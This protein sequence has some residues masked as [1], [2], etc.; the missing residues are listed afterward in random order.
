MTS[1]NGIY[2][3]KKVNTKLMNDS[4]QKKKEHNLDWVIQPKDDFT[5]L[6]VWY[7]ESFTLSGI[8]NKIATR[9]N[10]WFSYFEVDDKFSSDESKK[11]YQFLTSIDLEAIFTDMVVTGNHFLEVIKS[12]DNTDARTDRVLVETIRI[13]EQNK[14]D[15]NGITSKVRSYVQ[16]INSV[17]EVEFNEWEIIHFKT[18]NI[19]DK[20]YGKSRLYSVIDQ[21]ILLTNIDKFY[22][23][24]M[25]RGNM[26]INLLTD[27]DNKLTKAQK[28]AIASLITDAGSGLDNAFSTLIIPSWVEKI[29]LEDV[30]DT[31]AFLEYR[32]ELI[33]SVCIW[34]NF[35]YE[36]L[37]ADQ[38]NKSTS[39]VALKTL[40]EDVI[41]PLQD[42]VLKTIKDFLKQYKPLWEIS[43]DLIELI[44]FKMV[45]IENEKEKAEVLTTYVKN[46]VMT[47]NEARDLSPYNLIDR[48]DGDDFVNVS[49]K[50]DVTANPWASDYTIEKISKTISSR[51]TPSLLQKMQNKWLVKNANN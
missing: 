51:Y 16:G 14:T 37:I 28:D 49:S 22:S 13:K 45:D 4:K 29:D 46:K 26:R 9:A 34:C 10:V 5:A 18:N 35:P 42:R 11:L 40:R 44:S 33:K 21:V 50:E 19:R 12:M 3:A 24:L 7:E 1:K 43:E 38:S 48:P 30:T 47:P 20:Y 25:D 27:K 32:K 15:E 8:V 39:D 36:M 6:V 2:I 23:R 17:N 41:V 31:K